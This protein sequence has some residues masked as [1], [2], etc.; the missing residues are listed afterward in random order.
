MLHRIAQYVK[1][2][3]APTLIES[4]DKMHDFCKKC[5]FEIMKISYNKEFKLALD[6]WHVK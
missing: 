2:A 5:R 6:I 1:N 4:F 3:R